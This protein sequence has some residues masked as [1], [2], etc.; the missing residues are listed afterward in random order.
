MAVGVGIWMCVGVGVGVWMCV[1][2]GVGVC[3]CVSS[4]TNLSEVHLEKKSTAE[5]FSVV[6]SLKRRLTRL[7]LK[8]GLLIIFTA[9][10]GWMVGAVKYAK[11]LYHLIA[12]V[13][14]H[15]FHPLL[16]PLTFTPTFF[17]VNHLVSVVQIK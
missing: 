2:V 13:L 17:Y 14:S 8:V 11:R 5:H 12:T 16:K 1:G 15:L 6:I 4:S 3:I 10:R 9:Y 7:T